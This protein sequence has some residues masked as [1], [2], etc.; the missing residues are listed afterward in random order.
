MNCSELGIVLVKIDI[1]PDFLRITHKLDTFT[2]HFSILSYS[3]LRSSSVTPLFF[4]HVHKA[5]IFSVREITL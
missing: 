3:L 4:H 1:L 2:F 5:I